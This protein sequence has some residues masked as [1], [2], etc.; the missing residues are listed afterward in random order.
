MKRV[1][2]SLFIAIGAFLIGYGGFLFAQSVLFLIFPMPAFNV[3]PVAGGPRPYSS[4]QSHFRHCGDLDTQEV[5]SA[6]LAQESFGDGPILLEEFTERGGGYVDGRIAAGN[7]SGV[8]HSTIDDYALKNKTQKSLRKFFIDRGDVVFVTAKDETALSQ[9]KSVPFEER[10]AKRFPGSERIVS[11][12]NIGFNRDH[13][14]ALVY[15][16]FYCGAQCAGGSLYTLDKT[17]GGWAVD[18]VIPLWEA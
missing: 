9:D 18:R 8:E 17:N 2:F 3:E 6:V 11:L 10:L 1:V 16:S 5:Y 14:Q 4:L 13:T 12:S 15:V 7:V